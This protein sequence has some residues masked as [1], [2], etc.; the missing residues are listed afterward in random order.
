MLYALFLS[1]FSRHNFDYQRHTTKSCELSF[2]DVTLLK[3]YVKTVARQQ[4]RHP[5]SIWAELKRKYDFYSYKE[6]DCQTMETIK[7]DLNLIKIY[8]QTEYIQ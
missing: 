1:P 7:K 3:E 8:K 2:S 4:K 5:N 6:I